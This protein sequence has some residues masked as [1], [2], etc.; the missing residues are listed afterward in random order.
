MLLLP[1]PFAD[2]K[3]TLGKSFLVSGVAPATVTVATLYWYQGRGTRGLLDSL[4]FKSGADIGGIGIIV[5]LLA[6]LLYAAALELLD[7]VRRAPGDLAANTQKRKDLAKQGDRITAWKTLV[8]WARQGYPSW[9]PRKLCSPSF[10]TVNTGRNTAPAY[11][12]DDGES[13]IAAFEWFALRHDQ[14]AAAWP[15]AIKPPAFDDELLDTLD[16]LLDAKRDAWGKELQDSSATP[17]RFR[18]GQIDAALEHYPENRYGMAASTMLSRLLLLVEDKDRDR[19]AT[20][21]AN[22]QSLFGFFLGA[23][24]VA[25]WVIASSGW[26]IVTGNAKA[27]GTAWLVLLAALAAAA[28]AWVASASAFRV[29]ATQAI[30]T[31]DTHRQLLLERIGVGKDLELVAERI[32]FERTAAF[33]ALDGADLWRPRWD[34][35]RAKLDIVVPSSPVPADG[36]S[37]L[38]I[39]VVLTY[40]GYPIAEREIVVR[41]GRGVFSTTGEQAVKLDVAGTKVKDRDEW[42][43]KLET[44][45]VAPSQAG[46]VE[47]VASCG[48][49]S[50]TATITFVLPV[51][52]KVEVSVQSVEPIEMPKGTRV[53]LRARLSSA[54]HPEARFV[55]A[56]PAFSAEP[57]AAALD[58]GSSPIA[59]DGAATSVWFVP[60]TT[61]HVA[62]KATYGDQED[63][64]VLA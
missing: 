8:L 41:A 2:L 35:T 45:Y 18:L 39:E 48:Q 44:Y 49:I 62:F 26:L 22:V 24:I 17:R 59:D 16:E 52:N 47:L 15:A 38:P 25:G 40:S 56:S 57:A 7:R 43:A 19:L 42:V 63:K 29:F 55:G 27:D 33:F 1:D 5:L 61:Q 37:C 31:I 32:A 6:L 20:S 64:A 51:V 11:Q 50:C 9:S 53:T 3:D 23:V 28:V 21:K 46:N 13:I 34:A 4:S 60:A 58:W 54:Q 12:V 14:L 36:V 30:C 10:T